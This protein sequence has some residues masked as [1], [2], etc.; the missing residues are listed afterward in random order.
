MAR[1]CCWNKRISIR[2]RCS[3]KPMA[4]EGG[5]CM[6]KKTIPILICLVISPL[7]P[8]DLL[9]RKSKKYCQANKLIWTMVSINVLSPWQAAPI[10]LIWKR[11][12]RWFMPS[13]QMS[14]K[15]LLPIRKPWRIWWSISEIG[16]QILK[17]LSLIL[18]L[19]RLTAII[20]VSS[21]WLKKTLRMSVTTESSLS[22]KTRPQHLE[23]I[24]LYSLAITTTLRFVH[25]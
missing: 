19:W 6:E 5:R 3:L 9:H 15:T 22:F 18:F 16:K 14:V 24:R 12:C 8:M 20:L 17:A 1:R 11:W 4:G 25:W 13:L 21:S 10:L 23:T 7:V 2:A